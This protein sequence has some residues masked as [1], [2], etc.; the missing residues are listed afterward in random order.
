[1]SFI[2]K[3]EFLE[4]RIYK[5]IKDN[6]EKIKSGYSVI[7]YEINKFNFYACSKIICNNGFSGSIWDIEKPLQKDLEKYKKSIQRNGFL[8]DKVIYYINIDKININNFDVKD[9]EV[10]L[11]KNNT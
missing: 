4:E 11:I 6:I 7:N 3:L 10:I 8:I 5:I 1:M 9:I 2:D